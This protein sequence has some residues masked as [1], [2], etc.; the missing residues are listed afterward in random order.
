M[1]CASKESLHQ[2]KKSPDSPLYSRYSTLELNACLIGAYHV[3]VG[4]RRFIM[5]LHC[6]NDV[7]FCPNEEKALN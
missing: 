2:P 7:I 5:K 6:V 1:F 3:H 4:K